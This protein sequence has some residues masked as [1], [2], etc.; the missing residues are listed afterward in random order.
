M[1]KIIL[2]CLFVISATVAFAQP[3]MVSKAN[4]AKD[5]GELDIARECIEKAIV[6]AKSKD[7][8]RTHFVRAEIYFSLYFKIKNKVASAA[9]KGEMDKVEKLGEKLFDYYKIT[10][11][12]YRYC[13]ENTKLESTYNDKGRDKLVIIYNSNVAP[14]QQ[15]IQMYNKNPKMKNATEMMMYAGYL[16]YMTAVGLPDIVGGYNTMFYAY[17]T[18]YRLHKRDKTLSEE[19]FNSFKESFMEACKYSLEKKP[20]MTDVYVYY[21]MM[22]NDDE[23][24]EEALKVLEKGLKYADGAKKD[25]IMRNQIHCLIKLK[26][27][28]ETE[29]KLKQVLLSNPKDSDATFNLALLKDEKKDFTAAIKYYKK[30][31]SI[32]EKFVT[33]SNYNLGLIFYKAAESERAKGDDMDV[34]K[35]KDLATKSAKYFE[36]YIATNKNFSYKTNASDLNVIKVLQY[37]YGNLNQDDKYDEMEKKIQE[38]TKK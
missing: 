31:V 30:T 27:V 29:E 9:Q 11:S 15:I 6:H 26:R 37:C 8:T 24:Y 14:S 38:A 36:G 19:A 25:I 12:E 22:L 35:F 1:K 13:V 34:E 32:G 23:K 2:G 7:K 28:D 17:G 18:A 4:S 16:G 3:S 10:T 21:V 5:R 20:E 33:E